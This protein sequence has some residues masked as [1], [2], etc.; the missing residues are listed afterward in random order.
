MK[1]I[2]SSLGCSEEKPVQYCKECSHATWLVHGETT[3][4]PQ[5]GFDIKGDFDDLETWL[6]RQKE[7]NINKCKFG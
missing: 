5:S 3:F 2:C 1:L 4:N 7:I 6:E